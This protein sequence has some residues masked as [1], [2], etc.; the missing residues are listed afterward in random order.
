MVLPPYPEIGEC[1]RALPDLALDGAYTVL[2][3]G[4]LGRRGGNFL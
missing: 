4:E 1:L 2:V 3:V